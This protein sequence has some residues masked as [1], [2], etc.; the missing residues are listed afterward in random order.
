[1]FDVVV[2]GAG[3]AGLT[4]ASQLRHA[5]YK[6]V[7]V[8][9]SR[10][11]GGRV[12]T[13]RLHGTCA[14][15]G[16]K[17]LE[18]KDDFLR[19]LVHILSDRGLIVPWCDRVYAANSPGN[20]QLAG[21]PNWCPYFI[22]PT[23][24]SAIAK[25]MSQGLDIWLNRRS[26][27]IMPKDDN[28]WHIFL[29]NTGNNSE[30]KTPID[31]ISKAVVVAIPAPQALM[32]MEPLAEI[33]LPHY[34]LSNL[35]SVKFA[36]C[37]SV[38]AGYSQDRQEDLAKREIAWRSV[39]FPQDEKLAWLSWDSSKR[40]NSEYPVF[41]IHSTSTFAEKYLDSN[42]LI[43]AGNELLHHVSEYL[44]SWFNTPEWLQVDR[45]R[46]AFPSHILAKN[47][48]FSFKPLP[49]ACCGDWCLGNNIENALNSGFAA[50]HKIN[51]M[52]DNKQLLSKEI[53]WNVVTRN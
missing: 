9:K 19:R 45:W 12:T 1:M 15:R 33:G 51:R 52:L 8:E 26:I 11:L 42:D 17:F 37:L 30:D 48:L 13:R 7:V 50:A 25:F 6:V 36:A 28:L 31:I 20:L 16:A 35:R 49:I 38:I 41:V 43:P 21:V 44:D 2:I 22:P 18:P 40:N 46:Y 32:L 47:C 39:V 4:V 3:M 10:G 29:E 5:G 14:D 23:G 53:F 24:M 27:K 34:F